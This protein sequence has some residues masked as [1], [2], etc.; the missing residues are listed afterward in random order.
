MLPSIRGLRPAIAVNLTPHPFGTVMT[1][2]HPALQNIETPAIALEPEIGS[3]GR[4][5]S[6]R[7]G[8]LEFLDVLRG[9]AALVVVVQHCLEIVSQSFLRWSEQ[10]F[11]LGEFGVV[12]F[13]IVSGFIIPASMERYCSLKKFWLGRIFRLFPLYYLV[14]AVALAAHYFIHRYKLTS[15]FEAHPKRS[16]LANLTMVQDF[17]HYDGVIGASWTLSYEVVFYLLI[18]LLFIARINTRSVRL[19]VAATA[20]IVLVGL[21]LPAGIIA[22]AA[23]DQSFTAVSHDKPLLFVGMATVVVAVFTYGRATS[24]GH[25]WAAIGVSVFVIPLLFNQRRDLWFSLSLFALMFA[26]TVFYRMA[27][28]TVSARA[29]AVTV[30]FAVGTVLLSFRTWTVPKGGLAGE[31]VTARPELLTFG[32]AVLVFATFYRFRAL[33]FPRF[34]T[35]LGAVSYSV[36]LVH[37]VVLNVVPPVPGPLLGV[38]GAAISLAVWVSITLAVSA[39][40]YRYIEMPFQ[41]LGKRLIER[42]DARTA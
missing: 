40:T 2:I 1:S 5:T 14:V 37:V 18:S 23:G 7:R 15:G 3:T 4:T 32:G 11:R 27:K 6:V 30:L 9:L 12:L 25:R 39:L 38:P 16:A 8:R 24:R 26:G 17:L 29:G 33:P 22:S 19:S 31:Q 20:S 10:D 41:N 36:Y 34:L 35:W 13:F 21:F 42:I 28:S